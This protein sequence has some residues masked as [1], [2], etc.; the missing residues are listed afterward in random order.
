MRP[1]AQSRAKVT[2]SAWPRISGPAS[3]TALAL[4]QPSVRWSSSGASLVLHA[5]HEPHSCSSSSDDSHSS[6]P[7][8]ASK[9]S[10]KLSS[11][12]ADTDGRGARSSPV[13]RIAISQILLRPSP[14][15][16][17]CC[18]KWNPSGTDYV[19]KTPV[20]KSNSQKTPFWKCFF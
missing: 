11:G 18:W 9:A 1:L 5:Q 12:I 7:S 2:L 16:R 17:S 20:Y 14:E 10:K 15:Q 13:E 8:S 4:S 19:H 6:N 3:T